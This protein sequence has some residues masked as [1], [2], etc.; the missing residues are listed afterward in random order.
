M[1]TTHITLPPYTLLAQRRHGR[2]LRALPSTDSET[3]AGF[4]WR[5]SLNARTNIGFS[6]ACLRKLD[7]QLCNCLGGQHATTWANAVGHSEPD[8][9]TLPFAG[10]RCRG[11][12]TRTRTPAT[13][14]YAPT[15]HLITRRGIPDCA[16]SRNAH[17]HLLLHTMPRRAYANRH[18]TPPATRRCAFARLATTFFVCPTRCHS[19]LPGLRTTLPCYLATTRVCRRLDQTSYR[20]AALL[21]VAPRHSKPAGVARLRGFSVSVLPRTPPRRGTYG[22]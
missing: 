6:S 18:T 11:F 15:R 1:D 21:N 12:T 3:P 19:C 10:L 7:Y 13:R 17:A 5:L 16:F 20:W 14:L 9:T 22:L 2:H 8:D 4:F